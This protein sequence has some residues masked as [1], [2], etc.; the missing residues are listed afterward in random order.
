M[1]GI[2]TKINKNLARG[3]KAEDIYKK[4]ALENSV[5]V[6]KLKELI[7]ISYFY[8]SKTKQFE[9]KNGL[10]QNEKTNIIKILRKEE[11]RGANLR[12]V[13]M[14]LSTQYKTDFETID[15][16]F[17]RGD[18]ETIKK[19]DRCAWC[20]K[21]IDKKGRYCTAKCAKNHMREVSKKYKEAEKMYEF[22]CEKIKTKFGKCDIPTK[23]NYELI[24]ELELYNLIKR[25]V[26]IEGFTKPVS[27]MIIEVWR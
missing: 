21:E 3:K 18:K 6:K 16:L 15:K 11:N 2:I 14:K 10:T 12:G 8:N 4:I 20:G 13:I 5:C 23:E 1:E 24:E 9:K 7:K 19:S 22:L 27:K 17:V 26:I 25:S